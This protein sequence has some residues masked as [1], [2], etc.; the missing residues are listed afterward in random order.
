[1]VILSSLQMEREKTSFEKKL[2]EH[3]SAK[4]ERFIFVG[5]NRSRTAIEKGYS[6]NEC[7]KSNK[8]VLSAIRLFDAFNYCG[9]NPNEQIILNLW[10]DNG[11]LNSVVLERLNG[12][13]GEGE[14]II[15]MGKK[16]QAILD[17]FCIPHRKLIHPAA[18]GKIARR[19]LYREHFSEIVLS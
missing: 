16:V 10:N 2:L 13:V 7:Q 18:R 17:K 9:L 12:Y 5:E 11:E 15:G 6:W 1:M 14:I 3:A 8:P 19:T 4:K